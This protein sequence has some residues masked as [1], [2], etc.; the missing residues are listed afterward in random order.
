MKRLA[1]VA[2][3]A[4][5]LGAGIWLGIATTTSSKAADPAPVAAE[6]PATATAAVAPARTAR[7]SPPAL[8]PRHAPTSVSL[9]ADLHDADPKVRRAATRELARG[10][11]PDPAALLAA[12]RDP[13]LEVSMVATSGLGKLYADGQISTADMVARATDRTSQQRVHVLA[14]NGLGTVPTAEAAALLTDLLRSGDV[15]DRRSAANL[16]QSQ[17]AELASP[18]LIDALADADEGVR[19]AA[20][21]SLRARSRGRDFGT[22]A[23]AWR[24]WWQAHR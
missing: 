6:M 22:D 4:V 8:S 11:D 7:T 19:E 15:V 21:A 18:P 2:G 17:D 23:A 24:A 10:K 5:L 14:L 20:L 9:A 12:A 1:L 13:D 3:A 16:L